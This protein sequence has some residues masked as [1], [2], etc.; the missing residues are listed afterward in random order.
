MR[1]G[2]CVVPAHHKSCWW[3]RTL[4]GVLHTKPVQSLRVPVFTKFG[5]GGTTVLPAS[6]SS[7]QFRSWTCPPSTVCRPG[8]RGATAR[9]APVVAAGGGYRTGQSF[10]P[11][12]THT[13]RHWPLCARRQSCRRGWRCSG[14]RLRCDAAHRVL[15]GVRAEHQ[16]QWLLARVFFKTCP[17]WLRPAC[18]AAEAAQYPAARRTEPALALQAVDFW[19]KYPRVS[20]RPPP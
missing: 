3:R 6:S 17:Q 13:Y 20:P 7:A 1:I 10:T 2:C 4:R 15:F 5:R 11:L 16:Y 9:Q 12:L 19:P 8:I 18:I 14:S